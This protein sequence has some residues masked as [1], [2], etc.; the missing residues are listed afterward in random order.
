[1]TMNPAWR[2]KY[3]E[4]LLEIN[5]EEL[6]RRIDAAERAIQERIEELGQSAG[7]SSEEQQAI[8]DA[9]R[10]LRVLAKTE[11][12]IQGPLEPGS[13]ENKVAS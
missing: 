3:R 7:S 13:I 9:L 10:R 12:R 6:P 11:C 8:E 2:G 1:M 4:A 5:P